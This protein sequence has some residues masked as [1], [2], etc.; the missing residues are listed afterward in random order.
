MIM[1]IAICC[2]ILT[3]ATAEAPKL[4]TSGGSALGVVNGDVVPKVVFYHL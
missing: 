2:I 3:S 1:K 4:R